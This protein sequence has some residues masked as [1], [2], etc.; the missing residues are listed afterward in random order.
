[1]SNYSFARA[2]AAMLA[3][4]ASTVFAQTTVQPANPQPVG[5]T[6]QKANEAM[7]KAVPQSNVG[8]VVRTG[9]PASAAASAAVTPAPRVV[10]TP[11]VTEKTV[12]KVRRAPRADRG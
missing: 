6:Q 1:M 7:Q 4:T 3:V 9:E 10:R 2:A 5:T 11:V 8:T 12:R